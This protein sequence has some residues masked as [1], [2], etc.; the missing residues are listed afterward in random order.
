[1]KDDNPSP[2]Y[3]KRDNK[4]SSKGVSFCELTHSYS[5]DT[6]KSRKFEQ[7]HQSPQMMMKALYNSLKVC[8]THLTAM[9]SWPHLACISLVY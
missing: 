7:E 3:F 5:R 6:S 1:M 8:I 4:Q 2:N 9:G